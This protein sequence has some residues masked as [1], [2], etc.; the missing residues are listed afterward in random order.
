M[1][2][3]PPAVPCSPFHLVPL[4]RRALT[5]GHAGR[6]TYTFAIWSGAIKNK[7]GLDQERLQFIASAAN[8]GGYSSIFS[9]LMYD[10]LEKHK[11]VGPRVVVMIGCAANALG[12]IGLWAAVKG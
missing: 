2:E 6:L 7:Y 12:Y 1:G 11:R 4:V 3:G 8:V 9:G 5:F 10:A